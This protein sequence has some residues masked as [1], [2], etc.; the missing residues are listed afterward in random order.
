LLAE[1]FCALTATIDDAA[2]GMSGLKPWAPV[3]SGSKNPSDPIFA[4][5]DKHQAATTVWREAVRVEF[6]YEKNR[7]EVDAM[8]PR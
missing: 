8:D 3:A 6:A 4:I 1:D 2:R 5:I 7:P